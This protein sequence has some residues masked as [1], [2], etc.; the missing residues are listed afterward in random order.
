MDVSKLEPGFHKL[1]YFCA[2]SGDSFTERVLEAFDDDVQTE[3]DRRLKN[4]ENTAAF[5][6]A[7]AI[8]RIQLHDFLEMGSHGP[9]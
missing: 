4:D 5:L 3:L 9:H 2:N 6:E 8:A 7:A 1:S